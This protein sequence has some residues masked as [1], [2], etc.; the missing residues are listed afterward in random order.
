MSSLSDATAEKLQQNKLNNRDIYIDND[1]EV[2]GSGSRG[3][4]SHS[5][6]LFNFNY[7]RFIIIKKVLCQV[8]KE[9]LTVKSE[10]ATTK[11]PTHVSFNE[12]I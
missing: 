8:C 2:E 12:R 6:V 7:E 10:K 3:E 11:Y 5:V 9:S 1:D 4:V